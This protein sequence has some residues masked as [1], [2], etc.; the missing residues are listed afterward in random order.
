MTLS[1]APSHS[2]APAWMR[3]A[4]A[5]ACEPHVLRATTVTTVSLDTAW[6][7]GAVQTRQMDLAHEHE[8]TEVTFTRQ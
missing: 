8:R 3:A 2:P 6:P 4:A 1:I 5:F 7:S